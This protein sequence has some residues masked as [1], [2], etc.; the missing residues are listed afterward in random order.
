MGHLHFFKKRVICQMSYVN[1]ND[2][3]MEKRSLISSYQYKLTYL[4]IV[5]FF[6]FKS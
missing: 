2:M 1:R 5:R 3:A 4:H 6:K